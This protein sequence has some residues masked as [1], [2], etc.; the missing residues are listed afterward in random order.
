V[1]QS[2]AVGWFPEA[3]WRVAL[4]RWP[5]LGEEMPRAHDAYRAAIEARLRTIS[6]GTRGARL[7]MVP[8]TV[9][10]IDA[11]AA[12]HPDAD[13]GSAEL[14][15]R[16]ASALAAEGAGVVWPPGRNE[17]CWCGSGRKYKTCCAALP[18][19]GPEPAG[20]AEV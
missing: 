3:E 11:H 13:P 14:R 16:T 1:L 10:A 12:A 6:A 8:L 20:G 4:E 17:A 9:E 2:L 18:A 7:V 15:G 19:P 5:S